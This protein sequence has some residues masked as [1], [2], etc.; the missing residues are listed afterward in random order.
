MGKAKKKSGSKAHRNNPI[1]RGNS[2]ASKGALNP[3]EQ[4]FLET[5]VKPLLDTLSAQE[6]EPRSAALSEITLLC[7]DTQY[8]TMFL[9]EKLLKIVLE[10]AQK[11]TNLEVLKEAYGLLRNVAIEEGHDSTVFLWRQGVVQMAS[12]KL[13]VEPLESANGS[14]TKPGTND[15]LLENIISLFT[16]MATSSSDIFDSI[17]E[18]I[19]APFAACLTSIILGYSSKKVTASLFSVACEAA[20]TFS[21]DNPN[22]LEHMSSLPLNIIL[23]ESLKY[24]TLGIVY[25]N[26]LKYHSVCMELE[27]PNGQDLNALAPHVFEIVKTLDSFISTTDIAQVLQ[28]LKPEAM[29]VDAPA[30]GESV[31]P[32]KTVAAVYKRVMKSK[33]LA[34]GLQVS[35]E[36]LTAIAETISL[37]PKKQRELADNASKQTAENSEIPD[38]EDDED[39]F[40]RKPRP[41]TE[42]E[43]TEASILFDSNA[44]LEPTFKYIQSNVVPT[45]VK[46]LPF[47]DYVSRS[48]AALNNVSWA[49][50]AYP[51]YAEAWKSQSQ[52]LWTDL[53]PRVTSTGPGHLVEIESIN[54]ALGILWAV[55]SFY[56]G[57]VPISLEQLNFLISQSETV[58]QLY[59]AEEAT[60]HYTKLIGFFA[61]LAK[62]QSPNRLEITRR[63]AEYYLTILSVVSTSPK[64]INGITEETAIDTLDAI[65]DVFGDGEFSYDE[66]VYVQDKI[67]DK[68]KKLLPQLRN[69]FKRISKVTRYILR[70]RAIESTM[71]L[72]S[73]IDYK[74]SERNN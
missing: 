54:S 58:S 70:Q 32:T 46:I 55:A 2:N 69:K 33:S 17:E 63:V 5:K 9:K 27:K 15:E 38:A 41:Q 67:N 31:D 12:S 25:L 4:Q 11:E 59:P 18:Q 8:R 40:I 29:N 6:I 52:E 44:S 48:L 53:L 60:Q 1:A 26:G 65:F 51:Q 61:C 45:L 72:A 3:K 36:I 43:E 28:D 23:S 30:D 50:E 7:E 62:H 37:D 16:A 19:G 49:L 22:F 34:E 24:P 47:N 20:Y 14:E 73:F 13:S 71:T 56:N 68:L 74:T 10:L 42:V 66:P 64:P 39:M 57:D 21:E 35:I